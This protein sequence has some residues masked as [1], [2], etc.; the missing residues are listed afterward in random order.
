MDFQRIGTEEFV[1]A[2]TFAYAFAK[3]FLDAFPDAHP[4]GK[5]KDLL[6]SLEEFADDEKTGI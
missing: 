1:N 6:K 2:E 5:T 4:D 3:E